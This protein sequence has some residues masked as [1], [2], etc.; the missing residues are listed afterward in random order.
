MTVDDLSSARGPVT[1]VDLIA[2]TVGRFNRGVSVPATQSV[3]A[4]GAVA[5]GGVEVAGGGTLRLDLATTVAAT[6]ATVTIQTSFDNGV[7]DAWRTV[8]SFPAQTAIGVVRQ[9]FTGLDRWVRANV[10]V[11]T[12]GPTTVSVSGELV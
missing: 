7:T 12:A 10:T 1:G 3:A 8:A 6:S 2:G 4:V 5:G 9:V 11:L